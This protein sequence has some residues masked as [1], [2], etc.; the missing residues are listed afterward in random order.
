MLNNFQTFQL[1][2]KFH[3]ACKDL[4]VS[5]FLRDQLLRAS[6][7]IAL[8]AAEGSG[9]N[10][11]REQSRYYSISLGSLRECQAILELEN[12]NDPMLI[13]MADQLGAM[14]FSLSRLA[15]KPKPQTETA[16]ETDCPGS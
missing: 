8:N 12:I 7:S 5:S 3:W 13:N 2:K 9:K 16:T 15:T 1:A 4:K 14:L 10:T 11:A 6:S